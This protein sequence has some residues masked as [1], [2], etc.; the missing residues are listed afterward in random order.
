MRRE[1]EIMCS[2]GKSNASAHCRALVVGQMHR[3]QWKCPT[4]S[5][6]FKNNRMRIF[7]TEY[8]KEQMWCVHFMLL[9]QCISALLRRRKHTYACN[10][11]EASF[12]FSYIRSA[13]PLAILSVKPCSSIMPLDGGVVNSKT[14]IN[15]VHCNNYVPQKRRQLSR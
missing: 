6:R 8:D 14:E 2:A 1:E 12:L 4:K 10:S 3:H 11:S 15:D 13:N 5:C 7:F 9:Y